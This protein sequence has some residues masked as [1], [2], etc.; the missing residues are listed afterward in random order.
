MAL[1]ASVTPAI[2]GP[3]D[4]KP[5]SAWGKGGEKA[6]MPAVKVG[7]TQAPGAKREA[8]P[9]KAVAEWRRAQEKRAEAPVKKQEGLAAPEAEFVP[10]GQGAVPW[11]QISDVRVT[12]ALVARVNYSTGNLML[13]ATDLDVAGVGKTVQLA[14][15]YNSLDA[16]WGKVSRRWWQGYERYLRILPEE[17]KVVLYDA[18]GGSV[19]FTKKA[20]GTFTTPKGYRLDLEQKPDK[21]YV[22]T[23]RASGAKDTYSE[24][25]TLTKVTDRNGGEV[26]VEQHDEGAEHKGFKLTDVRSGRFVDLVRTDA[27]QWQAK[28]NTGRTVVMDLDAAGNLAKTTDTEGKSTAFG[29]D[30]D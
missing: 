16:P 28:D 18:S 23:D 13:A 20:D 2:A 19:S 6:K 12:D 22:L 26:R 14:R 25:G 27:A 8:A 7:K 21:S 10:S 15:T 3:D 11:Q 24:G 5:S 1:G 17:N 30:A 4:E 29:Y 9:S